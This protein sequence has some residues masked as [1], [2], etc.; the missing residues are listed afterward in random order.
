MKPGPR[1]LGRV[2]TT[3]NIAA[4]RTDVRAAHDSN[5][6]PAVVVEGLVKVFGAQRAV[7][8]IDLRIEAG[9][10]FGVLGPNGAGKTTMLRML[11]TLL[12]IDGGAA[13]VFGGDVAE[14]RACASVT[15]CR[16]AT[17]LGSRLRVLTECTR[18]TCGFV[19]LAGRMCALIG[20]F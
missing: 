2:T 13:T 12:G 15:F 14:Q 20:W 16:L 17:G 19:V 1:S 18:L 4:P 3:E 9:E 5:I 7:D 10:V 11:A 6:E 8:G